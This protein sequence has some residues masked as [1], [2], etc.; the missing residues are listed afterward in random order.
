MHSQ[1]EV[2]HWVAG[3]AHLLSVPGPHGICAY[4][5]ANAVV[6][7]SADYPCRTVNTSKP[8]G[9]IENPS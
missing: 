1:G 7:E 4:R 9:V 3:H 8:R 2:G 6:E 5:F